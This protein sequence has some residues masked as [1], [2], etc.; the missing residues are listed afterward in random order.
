MSTEP[1]MTMTDLATYL[2]V[3]VNTIYNWRAQRKGPVGI[4]VGRE[5]RF[6]QADVERWLE[7]LADS[8][9]GVA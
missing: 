4:K 1:L 3:A 6:R 9:K 8:E 5:V 2:G 7:S